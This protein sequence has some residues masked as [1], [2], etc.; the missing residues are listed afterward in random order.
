MD[1]TTVSVDNIDKRLETDR[2]SFP[3]VRVLMG[4]MRRWQA[5]YASLY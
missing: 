1:L 2:L 5:T 3:I 4:D